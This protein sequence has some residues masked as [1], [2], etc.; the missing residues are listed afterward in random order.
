M[1]QEMK[2]K[3]KRNEFPLAIEAYD[4]QAGIRTEL[5]LN[6]NENY[7]LNLNCH[8]QARNKDKGE[9]CTLKLEVGRECGNFSSTLENSLMALQ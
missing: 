7:Y 5:E 2:L 4:G 8:Y 6:N 9:M 3:L 1:P